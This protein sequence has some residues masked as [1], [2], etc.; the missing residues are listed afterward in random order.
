MSKIQITYWSDFI[1]PYCYIAEKRMKNLLKELNVS[2]NFEFRLLSFELDPNAPKKRP[3]NIVENFAKKYHI[4]IEE[5]KVTVEN[6]NSLGKAE[7]IDFR[8]DT[9][10]GGN[11]FKA[12]RLA[13]YIESKGNYQNSD[14]FVDILYDAYFTKIY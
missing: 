8:Y 4:S 2:Q 1:C 12:H 14:K 9:C 10:N 6:I 7:G 11:T 13:K 5:A 3:L